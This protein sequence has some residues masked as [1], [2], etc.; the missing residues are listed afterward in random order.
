[1]KIDV[2][3]LPGGWQEFQRREDDYLER[4][5]SALEGG[6]PLPPPT[7]EEIKAQARASRDSEGRPRVAEAF[8][9]R[10]TH[11]PH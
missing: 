10:D 5:L 6:V 7:R 2:S 1:M 3:R 9:A 11:A 4:E 8:Y